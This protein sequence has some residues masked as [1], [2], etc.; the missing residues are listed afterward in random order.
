LNSTTGSGALNRRNFLLCRDFYDLSILIFYYLIGRATVEEG[1]AVFD[2]PLL[3]QNVPG[4]FRDQSHQ[5]VIEGESYRK[6]IPPGF[7]V[8]EK[9]YSKR[10]YLE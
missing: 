10:G 2:E 1:M 7:D 4:R 9:R 5:L 3:G 8:S 6:R